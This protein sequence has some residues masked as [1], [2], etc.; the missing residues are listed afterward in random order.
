MTNIKTSYTK[1]NSILFEEVQMTTET[2]CL[3]VIFFGFSAT[4]TLLHVLPLDATSTATTEG[5]TQGKVNVLL[6]VQTYNEA[7]DVDQ[8]FAD[9]TIK[10]MKD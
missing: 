8:L 10:K 6:R 4:L 5:R 3:F 2:R 7:G 9:A 1:D